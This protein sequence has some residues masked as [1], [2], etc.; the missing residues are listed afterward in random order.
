MTNTDKERKRLF[1]RLLAESNPDQCRHIETVRVEG[2]KLRRK[3]A[4]L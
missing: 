1:K 3:I 2:R 4:K